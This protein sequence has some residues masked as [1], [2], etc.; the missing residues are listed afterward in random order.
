MGACIGRVTAA[1]PAN[2]PVSTLGTCSV[3]IGLVCADVRSDPAALDVA[4]GLP[5]PR[6]APDGVR[7]PLAVVELRP[8][9]PPVVNNHRCL[10]IKIPKKTVQPV[11]RPHGRRALAVSRGLGLW[12]AGD[13]QVGA[14]CLRHCGATIQ[15]PHAQC[16][17][18]HGRIPDGPETRPCLFCVPNVTTPDY[19]AALSA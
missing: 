12:W 7:W 16:P 13:G 17:Y 11:G 19:G 8:R 1:R 5:A 18:W 6:A 4:P 3:L 2:G 10:G 15:T 9:Q 14:N